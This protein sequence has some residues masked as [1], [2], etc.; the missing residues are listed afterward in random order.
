MSLI[1]ILLIDKLQ[2]LLELLTATKNLV[3]FFFLN[4]IRIKGS[5]NKVIKLRIHENFDSTGQT[6]IS[7][8]YLKFFREILLYSCFVVLSWNLTPNC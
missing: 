8:E 3:L 2:D 5:F 4:S 1:D 7:S 6:L